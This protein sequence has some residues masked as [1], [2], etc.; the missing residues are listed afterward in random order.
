MD[1]AEEKSKLEGSVLEG[2]PVCNHGI[3]ERAPGKG[4]MDSD[5]T[6]QSFGQTQ[7]G[8]KRERAPEKVATVSDITA[9]TSGSSEGGEGIG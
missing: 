2:A 8:G 3:R 1:A 9:G 4:A 7:L 6:T 5:I